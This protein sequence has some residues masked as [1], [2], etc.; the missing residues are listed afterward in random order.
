MAFGDSELRDLAAWRLTKVLNDFIN[1][2]W[3]LSKVRVLVKY[4]ITTS[5]N[6]PI[7]SLNI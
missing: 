2:H 1:Q 3:D 7:P 4:F 5:F 6:F